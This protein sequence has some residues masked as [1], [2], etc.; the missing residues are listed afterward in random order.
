M[1]NTNRIRIIVYDQQLDY[2]S[3]ED[4]G[5]K[6]NRVVDDLN[7]LSNKF[8]DFSYNFDLPRT[9]NNSKIFKNADAHGRKNIFKPNRDLPCR[10]YNNDRLLL[11][12]VIS[13]EG[14]TTDSYTCTFYSKLKEFSDAILD[15]T[16]K[17]LDFP[18]VNFDY[19]DT[20][21]NH[22]NADYAN[23]DEALY[24]FPFVYYGT[25]FTPTPT[26]TGEVDFNGKTFDQDTYPAQQYYYAMNTVA[27]NTDNRYYIHQ[28]PAAFYIV[29]I[30]EQIFTDA[31]WSI[32]GQWIN[33]DNIKKI[34][35]LYAGDNDIYDQATGEV[36]GSDSVTLEPSGLLP[37]MEQDKFL[38]GIINMFNLYFKIDIDNKIIKFETY[39]TLFTDT[40][41]P[42]NIT[43]KVFKETV[44]MSY[45]QN[46]N[47]A[48]TFNGAENEMV[49]GDN[50]GLSGSTNNSSAGLW[51][52]TRGTNF[53]RFFNKEGTTETIDIPFG[54]PTV[55]RSYIWNDDNASGALT[56]AGQ[57]IMF[58]PLMSEQTP[59]DND[60]KKFNKDETHSYL[61]NTEDTIKHN[62]APVLMYY[63]GQSSSDIV[64][65]T[66]KGA[67][68]EYFYQNIPSNTGSTLNRVKQGFCSP[69]QLSTF[70][71]EINTTLNE[72]DYGTR[73]NI[74][75][76]YLQGIWN[77][78]SDDD[79]SCDNT[80]DFSLVF[81]DNGYMHDSLWTK[82]HQAKYHRYQISEML[83]ADMRMND[84]DWSEMQ[85]DRPLEYNG[86]YYHLVSISG[87]DPIKRIATIK[88]IKTI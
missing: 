45:N 36:S 25:V 55:K 77:M 84:Y 57:H 42:Y 37:D 3:A 31:G 64:Q 4:L 61:Y 27:G 29:R 75:A 50:M 60:S 87:Y 85:I 19:E 73:K 78:M 17:D 88:L 81:D 76:S 39:K 56:N 32:G 72:A 80:T 71:D 40:F 26:Y 7:N 65:K 41:N 30:M 59:L 21:I 48:I 34:V 43:D 62:G 20:I 47:P 66:A 6:F 46:N 54:T 12:G 23:S 33:D 83:E 5:I 11:D 58:Q 1:A 68:S 79:G 8:G 74:T 22:I 13:L 69:F 44:R 18:D 38:N 86:E 2:K 14:I 52:K 63:Y 51:H 35:M 49:M 82:F 24:Q 53:K 16:L 70:R 15:K 10:V 9:K 28:F 67:Q